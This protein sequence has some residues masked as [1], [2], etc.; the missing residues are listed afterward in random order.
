M[1]LKRCHESNEND[2]ILWNHTLP[3][4]FVDFELT[5]WKRWWEIHD[6]SAKAIGADYPLELGLQQAIMRQRTQQSERKYRIY[7]EPEQV[8]CSVQTEERCLRAD[9]NEFL[10]DRVRRESQG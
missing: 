9:S 2:P 1:A 5:L 10:T 3:D 7:W 4:S 6:V 8:F